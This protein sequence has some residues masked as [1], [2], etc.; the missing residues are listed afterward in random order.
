MGLFKF[1]KKQIIVSSHQQPESPANEET[2]AHYDGSRIIGGLHW[3]KAQYERAMKLALTL[4]AGLIASVAIIA[5]LILTRPTPQFFAATPDLRLAPLEPLS[6]PL[7]TEQ[8]L[9]NWTT[10]T[11][12][13]AVSIDFVEWREK[14]SRS[15]EHFDEEAFKSFLDSLQKSGVLDLVRDKRLNVSASISRAPVITASGIVDGRATWRIEFPLVVSYESSQG[16]ENTQKLLASVLVRRANTARTPRGVVI[17]QVVLK[18][19]S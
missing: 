17:Q 12:T 4:G 14:L 11:V 2:H 7:L 5:L 19:D 13:Q 8:G 18:R 6:Q 16:V 1:T 10:E 3:Y 15:R 9:L